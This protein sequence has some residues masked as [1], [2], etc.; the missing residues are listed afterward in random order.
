VSLWTKCLELVVFMTKSRSTGWWDL[1]DW[2]RQWRHQ[3]RCQP[4][5]GHPLGSLKNKVRAVKND[6]FFTQTFYFL[7]PGTPYRS[8]LVPPLGVVS[9]CAHLGALDLW[10]RIHS[11]MVISTKCVDLIMQ[12]SLTDMYAKC[13]Y[14]DK[15]I[16]N[17]ESM[18]EKIVY[19]TVRPC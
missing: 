7:N 12:T 19:T 9:S 8:F 10:R 15:T 2:C 17:F 18:K 6:I 13:N 1:I 16:Q 4:A 3:G 5:P 14:I 11:Y